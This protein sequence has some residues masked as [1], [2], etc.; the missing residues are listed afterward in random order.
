MKVSERLVWKFAILFLMIHEMKFYE[1]F[2]LKN[3]QRLFF[4]LG[5]TFFMVVRKL[6]KMYP[7]WLE[8]LTGLKA[9]T[10]NYTLH[11]FDS[12]VRSLSQW[13]FQF[14]FILEGVYESEISYINI[15]S[16]ISFFAQAYSLCR[17]MQKT[18]FDFFHVQWCIQLY[19]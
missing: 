7:N 2:H 8:F 12:W 19:R 16:M 11:R 10:V 6:H 15:F 13:A 3:D 4:K 17:R 18:L 1:K 14:L 5:F 9:M